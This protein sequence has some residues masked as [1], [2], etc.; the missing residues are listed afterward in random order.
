MKINSEISKKENMSVDISCGVLK[1]R[2]KKSLV[3]VYFVRIYKNGL[4]TNVSNTSLKAALKPPAS[5]NT[6]C[7]RFR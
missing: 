5:S 4:V 6:A 7:Q 1:E 2:K 3:G